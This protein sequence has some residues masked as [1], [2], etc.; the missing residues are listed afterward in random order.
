[1]SQMGGSCGKN[2]PSSEEARGAGAQLVVPSDSTHGASCEPATAEVGNEA[3]R[4]S[5]SLLLGE[6]SQKQGRTS[7]RSIPNSLK[8]LNATNEDE[9][10][11]NEMCGQPTGR[12]SELKSI[13][14]NKAG[15]AV[16]I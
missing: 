16:I 4:Q 13:C 9:N 10:A 15:D 8:P 7:L 6:G 12:L 5:A 11:K 3:S 14:K 1:M 2:D